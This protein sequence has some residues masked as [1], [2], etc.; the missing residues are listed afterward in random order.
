MDP[1]I[2]LPAAA[3][4]SLE[5]AALLGHGRRALREVGDRWLGDPR[6][7]RTP[8]PMDV[9]RAP[10]ND[11]I[12]PRRAFATASISLE[13]VREVKKHFDVTINDVLL[14]LVGDAL[15]RVLRENGDL[16]SDPLVALCPVSHRANGDKSLDNQIGSMPIAIATH[17][18]DP[19]RRLRDIH[20]NTSQAKVEVERGRFDFLTAV[21]EVLAPK[22]VEWVMEL[23]ERAI[24]RMPLPANFVFSN[25]RG[26]PVPVYMAG[27]RVDAMYPMSIL[28]MGNG[29]NVTAVSYVDRIDFGFLVDPDLVPE[30]EK[31]AEA[32]EPALEALQNAA[33]GVVHRAG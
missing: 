9:P 31:L 17:M 15:R 20:R 10:F 25:V 18:A 21:G 11:V 7:A 12:G 30:P 13:A 24:D 28:Q 22:A 8:T 3:G 19:E 29:L 2:V 1:V 5:A 33:E 32:I 14:E 6:T 4:R 23:G 27:G 16:P 26:L